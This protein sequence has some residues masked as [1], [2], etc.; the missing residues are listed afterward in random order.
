MKKLEH[1][2]FLDGLE[3]KFQQISYLHIDCDLYS[4]T[5]DIFDLL[6]HLIAPGTVIVFDEYF[7]YAGWK[8]G[9]YLAFQEFVLCQSLEYQYITYNSMHEQVAILVT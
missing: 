6:G 3:N 4:S 8:D 9:E 2:Q 7:N 5:K 1:L